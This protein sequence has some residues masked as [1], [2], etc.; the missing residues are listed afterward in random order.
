MTLPAPPV[1]EAKNLQ[2]LRGGALVLD[3]PTLRVAEGEILAVIG[4]NGAGKST[5]LQTL[6]ALIKPSRGEIHFRG[7]KV[8]V[9]IPQLAYRRKLAM[10]LQEPL[11]FDTTV[12]HNVASGLKLRGLKPSQIEPIVQDTLERFAIAN[13]KE[14]SARTLSGGEARKVS[15]ARAFATQPEVLLLDEP[16]SALDPIVREAL[17][18]DL[19]QV[20][21]DTRLTTL[22]VTHDR[23][24]ALRLATH[25]GVLQAG[26]ML[27]IG[28]VQEVTHRPSNPFVA[29][30]TGIETILEGKVIRSERGM[31]GVT[32]SGQEIRALA[33]VAVGE[34]VTLCIRPEHVT[35]SVTAPPHPPEGFNLHPGTIEKSTPMGIYHK[36][37]LNCGF[38]LIAYVT[39]TASAQL[40]LQEGARVLAAFP[41]ADTHVITD[42]N[43]VPA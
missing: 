8:G 26:K 43:S 20:L 24:E 29:S 21:R 17:I 12:Y 27:Q 40:A 1:F 34:K 9:D 41:I 25:L 10:V 33:D 19:E 14:R 7:R 11:L 15:I 6:S 4:P 37:R 28:T 39:H 5:L 35:L 23:S 22:F 32:T 2:V 3:L 38:P 36:V 13:L 42:R 31:I 16:F 30:L 18:E